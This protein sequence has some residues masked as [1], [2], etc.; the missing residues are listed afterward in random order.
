MKRGLFQL[1]GDPIHVGHVAVIGLT[2][3]T[4]RRCDIMV[5]EQG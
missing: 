3:H 2:G 4:H 1:S 5:G